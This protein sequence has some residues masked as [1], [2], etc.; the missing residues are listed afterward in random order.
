MGAG[1]ASLPSLL[2]HSITVPGA[3]QFSAGAALP[4]QQQESQMPE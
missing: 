2:L 1:L 4:F 3:H